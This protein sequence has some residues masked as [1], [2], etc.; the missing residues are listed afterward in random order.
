M[1]TVIRKGRVRRAQAVARQLQL[2][3]ARDVRVPADQVRAGPDRVVLGRDARVRMDLE[4]MVRVLQLK[5][6]PLR[7]ARVRQGLQA[8]VQALQNRV[9]LV[10]AV[11]VRL[12]LATSQDRLEI[13]VQPVRLSPDRRVS[14]ARRVRMLALAV[15]VVRPVPEVLPG[16]VRVEVQVQVQVRRVLLQ[17]RLHHEPQGPRQNPSGLS[18]GRAQM[19]GSQAA[20]RRTSRNWDLPSHRAAE[21]KALF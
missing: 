17:A 16:L 8:H 2:A 6:G 5:V 11:L 21:G 18:L 14:Q 1:R 12:Q 10:R 3:P 9:D 7:R 20:P 13:Q 19:T 15:R 4:Q